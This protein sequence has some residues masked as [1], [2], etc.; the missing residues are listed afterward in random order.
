MGLNLTRTRNGVKFDPDKKW[1][2][3]KLTRTRHR[4]DL[5]RAKINPD[6]KWGLFTHFS[7]G[8]DDGPDKGL[9]S[10]PEIPVLSGPFYPVPRNYCVKSRFQ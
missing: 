6:E 4:H 8:P 10:R 7:S 2:L 5:I 9:K 1:G 3:L